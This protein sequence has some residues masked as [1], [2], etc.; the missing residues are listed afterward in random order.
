MKTIKNKNIINILFILAGSF[1]FAIGINTFVIPLN[2]GEG[3]VTGLSIILFYLFHLSPSIS[4][5]VLNGVLLIIGYK[6][7]DKKTC[8]YTII[9]VVF[10]SIFLH[11][12]AGWVIHL[13]EHLIGVAFGG[14]ISGLGI[15]MVLKAGGTTAGSA[16][17]ARIANKYLDWNLSYA[18]LFFDLIVVFC[19][20][21]I[22][23][24]EKVMLTIA[25]LYIGTKVIDFVV[26]GL[27]T[28]KAVTIISDN[29]DEIARE[30]NQ[31]LDRGVTILNGRGNY[32]QASREVIYAVINKQE[33]IK[34]KKIIRKIDHNAFVIIH[35]VRD[36]FGKGFLDI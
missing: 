30:I 11:I 20:F 16:I 6:F 7:L 9:A 23:G 25:M 28:K 15:G 5:F 1:L 12:T 34:L 13:H 32:T 33:L 22:I 27:N 24:A 14:V 10:N 35:D 36:V 19:S 3:G 8:I 31:T 29:K 17:L 4:T 21:F 2:L 18:L 26:E